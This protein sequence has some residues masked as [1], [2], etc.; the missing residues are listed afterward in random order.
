MTI[1]DLKNSLLLIAFLNIDLMIYILKIEF[2][3][4]DYFNKLI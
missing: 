1:F 3:K 4:L 2:N